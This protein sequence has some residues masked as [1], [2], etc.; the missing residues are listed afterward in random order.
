MSVEFTVYLEREAMPSPRD[1]AQAI[2]EAGFPAEL[3]KGFDVDDFAGFLSCRYAGADA[4]FE[5]ESGPIE[6]VDELE[7]PSDFDFSVTFSTNS[8]TR[9][10]AAAVV[11]AAVLC[12]LSRGI[13][14]DPQADS[15]VTSG[16]AISWAGEQLEEI[17]L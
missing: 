4:G 14:V 7:L 10:L 5:Y 12:S 9:E 15:V 3:D 1:W 6:Y 16:D 13:L 8:E 11:S 2:V 17:E